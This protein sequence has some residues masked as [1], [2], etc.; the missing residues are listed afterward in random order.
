MTESV[1]QAELAEL[2]AEVAALREQM[3]AL[4]ALT[5]TTPEPAARVEEAVA[6]V[7]DVLSRRGLLVKAGGMTAAA[8]VAAIAVT[9]ATAT[10]AAATVGTMRY[11]DI[12]DAGGDS[13][14]LLSTDSAPTLDVEN[15][16]S[17]ACIRAQTTH[18]GVA[19]QA[20]S[21]Y[22]N[23]V[24]GRAIGSTNGFSGV[25]GV[26]IG[27]GNGVFGEAADARGA[28]GVLGIAKGN[29]NSVFGFKDAG[30]PG[31]AVVGFTKGAGRGVL[32]IS[33]GGRGLVATGKTAQVQMTPGATATHPSSGQAGDF[34][35][36]STKRL[37]FC[38]GGTTW[39]LLA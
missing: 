8:A 3:A 37:W 18:G 35:V 4:L 30:I 12:N 21:G 34:F 33:S 17:G 36:D 7:Y 5:T 27:T 31:D 10:P 20:I 24:E 6:P 15:G 38:K 9:A 32:A 23:G 26:T 2:R 16:G 39:K 11:G 14:A 1:P 28:N 22:S 29:G 19:V 25:Y 13:T